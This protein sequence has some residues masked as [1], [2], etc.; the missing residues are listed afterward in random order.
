ML[1]PLLLKNTVSTV[2]RNACF[3]N[4]VIQILRRI[5]D[6][7]NSIN[8]LIPE[9]SIHA[10]LKKIFSAEG[11][12]RKVSASRLR[13]IVGGH[14]ASGAQMDCKEF[15]DELLENL[16]F[17]F[18]D[19]FRYKIKHY[20]NFIRSIVRPACH[21]CHLV[22]DPV[23]EL[24]TSLPVSLYGFGELS[25]QN[26]VDI[27]FNFEVLEKKCSKCPNQPE[28][29]YH[30]IKEFYDPG[31]FLIIQL[32]RF[33]LKDN[34]LKK[35]H[36]F[37]P[38]TFILNINGIC[39]KLI[40]MINHIGEFNNGHY[41]TLLEQNEK[42]YICDDDDFPTEISRTNVFS[43]E[44]YLYFF[45]KITEDV[46]SSNQVNPLV[47]LPSPFISN[48]SLPLTYAQATT[49]SKNTK[50]SL[51]STAESSHSSGLKSL[52]SKKGKTY[53]ELVDISSDD[54]DETAVFVPKPSVSN[55]L[56]STLQDFPKEISS[57]FSSKSN[58]SNVG[59]QPFFRHPKQH[60]QP[61]RNKR[62]NIYRIS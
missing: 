16:P 8:A 5:P 4:S 33:E 9:T 18:N 52:L 27:Y 53:I 7:K 61:Q 26:L 41:I 51:S 34:I 55:T 49:S 59:G 15:F 20:F 31:P 44:N 1:P 50:T 10:E 43:K 45:K 23:I 32:K 60:Q 46:G 19:L 47:S 25:L 56:P 29:T 13:S 17:P 22:E 12:Q 11:T 42:W 28:Q 3:A 36:T 2:D 21:Y 58:S 54:S 35:L 39:F 24:G 40:A 30:L 62:Q 37:V 14:F 38:G 6:I 57:W 48:S